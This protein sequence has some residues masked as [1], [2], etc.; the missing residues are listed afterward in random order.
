[1]STGTIEAFPYKNLTA[2]GNV[3][4]Q[5]G[6]LAGIFVATASS[7]PTL[8]VFDTAATSTTV[9]IIAAFTPVAATFYP[10]PALAANGIYV[11]IGGTVNCTP[12]FEGS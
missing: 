2:S 9:T 5:R 7:T 6:K 4:A 8:A 12:F 1:M 10:L 11:Q 3:L